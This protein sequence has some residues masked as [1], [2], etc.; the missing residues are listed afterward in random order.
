MHDRLV[1]A[2]LLSLVSG[3]RAQPAPETAMDGA[4]QSALSRVRA[5]KRELRVETFSVLQERA[6]RTVERRLEAALAA[7]GLPASQGRSIDARMA[8]AFERG[9]EPTLDELPELAAGMEWVENA[10]PQCLYLGRVG[11]R[12]VRQA[13]FAFTCRPETPEDLASWRRG[14]R[15]D[16]ANWTPVRSAGRA[17]V[18][19]QPE[20]GLRL[21]LRRAGSACILRSQQ[22]GRT[23]WALFWG[24]IRSKP[25]PSTPSLAEVLRLR[26]ALEKGGPSLARIAGLG[27]TAVGEVRGEPRLLLA[28]DDAVLKDGRAQARIL[29]ELEAVVPEAAG[30]PFRFVPKDML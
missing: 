27:S 2:L 12:L 22:D 4:F 5:A 15:R 10:P 11:D 19:E 17:L 13:T 6:R 20:Y 8:A 25:A 23:E 16:A 28:V 24:P 1:L 26:A 7:V 30:W 21:S 14:I 9:E 18:F 3:A 29:I